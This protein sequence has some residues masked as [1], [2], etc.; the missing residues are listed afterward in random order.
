MGWLRKRY[1]IKA[2]IVHAPHS[3][4]TFSEKDI[5][6]NVSK[7]KVG[8]LRKRCKILLTDGNIV[9]IDDQKPFVTVRIIRPR[10]TFS[11]WLGDYMSGL[12]SKRKRLSLKIARLKSKLKLKRD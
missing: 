11:R 10:S 9:S 4:F 6:E 5:F 1:P 12:F 8:P 7:I 2:T 3:D